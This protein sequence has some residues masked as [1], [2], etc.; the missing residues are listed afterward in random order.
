M[1]TVF[2]CAPWSGK[3]R[4]VVNAPVLEQLERLL[5]L[6]N[7]ML[8]HKLQEGDFGVDEIDQAVLIH[9]GSPELCLRT[10]CGKSAVRLIPH[11]RTGTV[12]ASALYGALVNLLD[13]SDPSIAITHIA[14]TC[15]DPDDFTLTVSSSVCA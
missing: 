5:P 10:A 14:Q 7:A 13:L 15:A 6:L 12:N 4:C 11:T 1:A 2:S 3:A 9:V 8:H